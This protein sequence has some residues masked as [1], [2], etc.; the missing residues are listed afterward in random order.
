MES[1]KI[2]NE[3]AATLTGDFLTATDINY[4]LGKVFTAAAQNRIPVRTA[5]TLAYLGQILLTTLPTVQKEFRFSYKFDQ[6]N[7]ML[8]NAV[9]LSPPPPEPTSPAGESQ[10][11]QQNHA[12]IAK[13]GAPPVLSGSQ[14]LSVI[15]ETA[16]PPPSNT[17]S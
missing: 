17:A 16:V 15:N 1:R 8:D 13:T 10:S 11:Q 4:V 7:N 6:W 3:I 2:G 12:A 5:H 9:R 14:D